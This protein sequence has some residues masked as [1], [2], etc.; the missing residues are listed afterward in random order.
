MCHGAVESNWVDPSPSESSQSRNSPISEEHHTP[1]SVQNQLLEEESIVRET[2]I[3]TDEPQFGPVEGCWPEN[4][5]LELENAPPTDVTAQADPSE[6][7]Q[8]R[9]SS[10][11]RHPLRDSV[12]V[13]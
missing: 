11:E 10:R 2:E 5:L 6:S 3:L 4:N 12:M 13:N 7:E 8:I 1:E 9:R